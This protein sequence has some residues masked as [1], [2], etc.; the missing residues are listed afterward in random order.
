MLPR[1]SDVIAA[2][3][4]LADWSSVPVLLFGTDVA[5]AFHQVPLHPG[6]RRFTAAAL[7]GIFNI[8]EVL[9]FGSGISPTV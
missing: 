6:E 4:G 5:N 3:V 9:E 1:I 8:F 7:G 2:V